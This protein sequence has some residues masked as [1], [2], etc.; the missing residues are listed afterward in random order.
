[1]HTIAKTIQKKKNKRKRKNREIKKLQKKAT[2][3]QTT[4]ATKQQTTATQKTKRLSAC[5]EAR[6]LGLV[7]IGSIL[8]RQQHHGKQ[9]GPTRPAAGPHPAQETT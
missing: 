2:N 1:V 3:Q 8:A 9:R 6:P 5:Q 7:A 4:T